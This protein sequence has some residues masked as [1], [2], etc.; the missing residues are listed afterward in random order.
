M[1]TLFPLRP[2]FDDIPGLW[3]CDGSLRDVYIQNIDASD[4][5]KFI[6]VL[7]EYPFK[8]S[9]DGIELPLPNISDILADRSG[10]HLLSISVGSVSVNCHFFLKSEI[11]L[12]ISPRE[13]EG[14]LQHDA[15][16][17]FVEHLSNSLQRPALLTPENGD[18]C[19]FLTYDPACRSW[20]AHD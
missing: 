13:I 9:F 16:I 15:V 7:E 17:V 5:Y 8:Y 11:E 18:V 2:Q 10:S 1:K 20:Y 3:T 14:Q 4:W 6:A 12:D 19:P